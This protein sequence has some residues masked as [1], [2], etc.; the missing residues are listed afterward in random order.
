[1]KKITLLTSFLLL[2]FV[3]NT[4]AQ[5]N[6]SVYVKII[7][8]NGFLYP[9]RSGIPSVS[10]LTQVYSQSSDTVYSKD[11]LFNQLPSNSVV[12]TEGNGAWRA[13]NKNC[14]LYYSSKIT[15]PFSTQNG[16]YTIPAT[17][18]Y[19]FG[20]S[21]SE[22][23]KSSINNI[24]L[25]IDDEPPLLP[26]FNIGVKASTSISVSSWNSSDYWSGWFTQY[27]PDSGLNGIKSYTLVIKLQSTGQTISSK[28]FKFN[29]PKTHLFSGLQPNTYYLISVT[30]TDLADN[31]SI[32]SQSALTAPAPPSNLVFSNTT[33][34]D[35]RLNWT[36]SSGASSYLVFRINSNGNKTQI[37]ETANNYFM[38]NGLDPNTTYNFEVIAKNSEGSISTNN[39]S[40]QIK[41][42]SLPS[43]TGDDY[44]CTGSKTYALSSL[45]SGYSIVWSSNSRLSLVSSSGLSATFS[46]VSDGEGLIYGKIIAPNG[47][48]LNLFPKGVWIGKPSTPDIMCPH[49]QVG[50]NSFVEATGLSNGASNYIWTIGGGTIYDG[51]GTQNVVIRTSS[52]CLYDLTIRLTT[53]NVCGNSSQRMR[54]IPYDCSGGVTPQGI[55]PNPANGLIRVEIPV[56]FFE[57]QLLSG[58]SN[59]GG[60]VVSITNQ[61]QIVV[62]QDLFESNSFDINIS[63]LTPG[64]YILKAVKNNKV[65]SQ[66]VIVY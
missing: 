24:K 20:K 43:I 23:T 4:V 29:D 40:K 8:N 55:Y 60:I 64:F 50:L 47:R 65:Y 34:I 57:N 51:Q 12:S 52:Q 48:E 42:L 2:L 39:N 53:Q 26:T 13:I 28:N 44:L 37:G 66:K 54:S 6:D 18:K 22:L 17:I 41:T 56:D 14:T 61:N 33:Y 38:I 62:F 25:I 58:V 19:K 5:K 1:M 21:G 49:Q 3:G 10:F 27:N 15:V 16:I 46:R 31:N 32:S 30:A 36:H 11:L 63:S 35:T 9:V 45:L 59:N 7:S